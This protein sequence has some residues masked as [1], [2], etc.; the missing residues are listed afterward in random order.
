MLKPITHLFLVISLLWQFMLIPAMA[1]PDLLHTVSENPISI[2]ESYS[3]SVAVDE[4]VSNSD[5]LAELGLDFTLLCDNICEVLA[6][7][8]CST[9][10]G[11]TTGLHYLPLLALPTSLESEKI[12]EPQW[13]IKT[14][15]PQIVNPP[16]IA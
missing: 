3:G 16:P 12:F 13:S 6:S 7:G 4:T 10:G 2:S 1:L 9:H 5:L 15:P 14:V 11:C 8:H